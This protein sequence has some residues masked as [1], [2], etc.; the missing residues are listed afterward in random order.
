AVPG[1]ALQFNWNPNAG[2]SATRTDLTWP[3]DAYVDSVGI[4]VYDQS[5]T[6][7]TYPIPTDASADEVRRRRA[8]VWSEIL[9]GTY[10]L[11]YWQRFAA[12]HGK[13]LSISEWGVTSRADGHGGGDNPD[14]VSNMWQFIQNPANHVQFHAY[15]D[16]M[17]RDGG[18][19]LSPYDGFTTPFPAASATFKRLFGPSTL[20]VKP[21]LSTTST[22]TSA[23]P[24][25][26]R[27]VPAR[28]FV[29]VPA[30]ASV[31]RV[32]FSIDDPKRLRP[33]L[34]IDS[35][36]PFDL[37]GGD[38]QHALAF[39][40]TRVRPGWHTLTVAARLGDGRLVVA[41]ARFLRR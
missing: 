15:F 21:R 19:Q 10:G 23:Q 17:A 41:N 31:Q 40:T 1:H 30:G 4:D 37:V 3:G 14:F 27:T 22:R 38:A 20:D 28:A 9:D 35:A 5:W 2:W 33:P 32:S 11:R 18:H 34:R 8:L 39:A 29:F 24:L 12:A 13:A 25:A 6:A 36:A 7:G 16:Y 26:D